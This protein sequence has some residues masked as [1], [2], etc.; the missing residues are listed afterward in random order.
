MYE[1]E[2][3]LANV[4]ILLDKLTDYSQITDK[5]QILIHGQGGQPTFFYRKL[6]VEKEIELIWTGW[7]GPRWSSIFS[8]I[9][10]QS[11]LVRLKNKN[12]L[13]EFCSEIGALSFCTIYFVT[14]DLEGII[15]SQIISKREKEIL[16][17]V[18]K[19]D[20]N[21]MLSIDFDY[22][23]GQLDG[24][25]VYKIACLGQNVDSKIVKLLSD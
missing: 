11:G 20:D 23:S 3:E 15:I 2:I 8:F 1:S 18:M 13:K 9:P 24:E 25:V 16:E 17:L 5:Y 21:F 14:K 12:R 19:S 6:K 4:D 7:S 22:H 10:G